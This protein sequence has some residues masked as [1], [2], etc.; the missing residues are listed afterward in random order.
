MKGLGLA[1][2]GA[3]LVLSGCVGPE[4][5]PKPTQSGISTPRSTPTQML[6]VTPTA[7]AT[8][9]V[10]ISPTVTPSGTPT[11]P[12]DTPNMVIN[13]PI[14]GAQIRS[15][16]QVAGLARVFEGTVEIVIRDGQGKEIGRGIAAASAGA[17]QRGQFSLALLFSPP[18]A[19]E[20][21]S[22]EAFSRNP[23]DGSV[24]NL[25]SVPVILMPN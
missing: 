5:P 3:V 12:L 4:G 21:G 13:S 20:P 24:D 23:R 7:S 25:V 22:I 1:L 2:A 9:S 19:Q 17:P 14:P 16:V 18:K 8:A 6:T 15:P 11:P 10:P